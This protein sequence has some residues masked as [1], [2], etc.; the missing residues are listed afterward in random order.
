MD[1]VLPFIINHYNIFVLVFFLL[2]GNDLILVVIYHTLCFV[3]LNSMQ[4]DELS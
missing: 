1:K 3:P 2:P 4:D